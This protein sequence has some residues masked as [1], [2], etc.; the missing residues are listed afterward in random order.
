MKQ[1]FTGKILNIECAAKD[2]FELQIESDLVYAAPGQFISVLCPNTTLRRPFSIADFERSNK[3]GI[4]T[5]LFKIKGDGTNYLS[6]LKKDDEIN[7]IAPLGN[8]FE[9]FEN[10]KSLLIG[11]G[12]GIAPMLYLKKELN[13]RNIENYLITGFKEQNEVIKGSDEI[14]LGGSVLDRLED[15]I[16]QRNIQIIY[17]CGP[18]PVLK[19][20]GEIAEKHNIISELALEKVM[21]CGI[22]VCRGCV[23]KLMK[24]NEI[25]QASICKDGPVF[26]GSELIWE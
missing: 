10:K 16:K 15:L 17:S 18:T 4:I 14:T 25:V 2:T 26:L 6:N 12:I 3:K 13:K 5:I 19:G 8:G 21:A 23:V 22:G 24:E 1:V 9:I 11:A 7:F 20:V